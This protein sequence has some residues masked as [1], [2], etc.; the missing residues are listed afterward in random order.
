M[1]FENFINSFQKQ[2]KNHKNEGHSNSSLLSLSSD[3]WSYDNKVELKLNKVL[4]RSL[5]LAIMHYSIK[6]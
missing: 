6:H 1:F 3:T 4:F 5:V 2:F